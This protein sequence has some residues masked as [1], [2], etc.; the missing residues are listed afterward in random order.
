MCAASSRRGCTFFCVYVVAVVLFNRH[1][2]LTAFT[3]NCVTVF[4][5]SVQQT[6]A[7]RAVLC[8]IGIPSTISPSSAVSRLYRHGRAGVGIGIIGIG[9]GIGIGTNTGVLVLAR[10]SNCT[11][12]SAIFIQVRPLRCRSALG[13]VRYW[14][15][16]SGTGTT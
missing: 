4:Q 12:T 3:T 8:F 7:E 16:G 5:C 14:E 13:V 2:L 6:R 1:L 10:R 11:G 9:I 15:T